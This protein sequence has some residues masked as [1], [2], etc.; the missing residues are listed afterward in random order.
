VGERRRQ[1]EGCYQG[2]HGQ[3]AR[4]AGHCPVVVALL[5][6]LKGR[7]GGARE[8]SHEVG[9]REVEGAGERYRRKTKLRREAG[10]RGRGERGG[11]REG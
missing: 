9:G 11:E 2:I 7:E 10:V 4:L 8:R 5:V 3:L 6:D 1:S